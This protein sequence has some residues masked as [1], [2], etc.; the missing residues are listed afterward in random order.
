MGRSRSQ[1]LE[2][3]AIRRERGWRQLDDHGQAMLVVV[4]I[5]GLVMALIAETLFQAAGDN[6]TIVGKALQREQALQAAH[7]GID[8][9]YQQIQAQTKVSSVPCGSNAVHGTLSGNR[10]ATY[11]VTAT[12]YSTTTALKKIACAALKPTAA[13]GEQFP[14][15]VLLKATGTVATQTQYFASL[16]DMA[17]AFTSSAFTNGIQTSSLTMKGGATVTVTDKPIYI[18]TTATCNSTPGKITTGNILI[19]GSLKV[20]C[21]IIGSVTAKGS[22]TVVSQGSITGPAGDVVQSGGT[23]TVKKNGVIGEPMR[24]RG[25]INITT[26]KTSKDSTTRISTDKAITPTTPKAEAFPAL[27]WTALAWQAA[28]YRTFTSTTCAA[29]QGK[30]AAMSTATTKWAIHTKNCTISSGV[31]LKQSLVFFTTQSMKINSAFTAAAGHSTPVYL[32]LV[33]PSSASGPPNMTFAG[34]GGA[35]APVT[36]FLY[37]EGKVTMGGNSN[38]GQVQVYAEA[39][40]TP[41]GTPS[42]TTPIPTPADPAGKSITPDGKVAVGIIYERETTP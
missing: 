23:I 38:F 41:H 22:I 32:Y 20:H 1:H 16:A 7:S 33:Q 13:G 5:L 9:A 8:A 36:A 37:T 26:K 25:K 40:Y 11:S 35:T 31:A 27:T 19:R 14:R 3:G 4:I 21:T 10:V 17:V 6:I 24:A 28:T 39:G 2:P 30:V 42:L 18:S 15:A 12:Y 34:T 29:V